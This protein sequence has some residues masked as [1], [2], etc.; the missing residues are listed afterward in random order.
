M[1][2]HKQ[3]H[4]QS[5]TWRVLVGADVYPREQNGVVVVKPRQV[6]LP[7]TE[8]VEGLICM[9]VHHHTRLQNVYRYIK[10][11]YCTPCGQ[12]V[13]VCINTQTLSKLYN[14]SKRDYGFGS[15]LYMPSMNLLHIFLYYFTTKVVVHRYRCTDVDHHNKSFVDPL[16]QWTLVY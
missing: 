13:T 15:L 1:V 5:I 7:Q 9:V 2:P 16:T 10:Y 12:F 6:G 14:V 3:T 11:F 8:P 4:T